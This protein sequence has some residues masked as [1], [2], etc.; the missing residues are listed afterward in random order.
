MN[1][2]KIVYMAIYGDP[3]SF[4]GSKGLYEHSTELIELTHDSRSL[5]IL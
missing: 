4:E 1:P 2:I 3:T 5:S